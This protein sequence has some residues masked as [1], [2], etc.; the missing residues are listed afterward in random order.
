MPLLVQGKPQTLTTPSGDVFFSLPTPN[1]AVPTT[2]V[3]SIL[4]RG[5]VT[6][7]VATVTTPSNVLPVTLT[8][9]DGVSQISV[10]LSAA[11]EQ[12]GQVPIRLHVD[13]DLAS[14]VGCVAPKSTVAIVQYAA[15]LLTG[16]VL[17]P[18]KPADF[19]PTN[20]QAVTVWAPDLSGL[21]EQ[22]MSSATLATMQAVAIV[23]QQY[24]P[25]TTVN[26][27]TGSP[28]PHD[29]GVLSRDVQISVSPT[30]PASQV[31]V[32][33]DGTAPVLVVSGRGSGLTQAADTIGTARLGLATAPSATTVGQSQLGPNRSQVVVEAD[34]TRQ[35]TL[36]QLG[37]Q[38]TLAG[39]GSN[40]VSQALTQADFGTPISQLQVRVQATYTPLAPNS[41]GTFSVL[42]GGYIV[43]SKAL[44]DSG[45]LNFQA[46]TPPSILNRN[47]QVEY[48]L[49][50]SPPGG[51]CLSGALPMQL[52]I[53]PA[54]GFSARPG[55]T[56]T[57]GFNRSPQNLASSL[58]VDLV[59]PTNA[60]LVD[61]C[62]LLVSLTQILPAAPPLHLVSTSQVP[63]DVGSTDLVMGATSTEASSLG[64]PLQLSPFPRPGQ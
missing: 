55:Q 61:A 47:Q 30:G 44:G 63:G 42:V 17:D 5:P 58:G 39:V 10:P 12:N 51:K 8:T 52:T 23:A 20:L 59:T 28:P 3:A 36:A 49:N 45:I 9:V 57:P 7:G 21:S 62:R 50:Y 60:N 40:S 6:G 25:G 11:D 38:T 48:L 35:I 32:V 31:H 29:F 13:L 43:A 37:T 56:L 2:F 53:N 16:T 33:Q 26:V 14:Q 19:W 4:V 34:G 54:S 18:S 46:N 24:G 15:G 1:G 27:Q 41:S 22:E 64:G